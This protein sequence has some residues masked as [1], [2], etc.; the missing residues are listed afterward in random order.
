MTTTSF[1]NKFDW[2]RAI[3]D[4]NSGL[5]STQHHIALALS[6]HL[7]IQGSGFTT[8]AKL[9]LETRMSE[10]SVCDALTALADMHWIE[11][12][13]GK[14]G[15]TTNY[16]STKKFGWEPTPNDELLT[17]PHRKPRRPADPDGERKARQY[18]AD[19]YSITNVER[20]L[21]NDATSI[22]RRLVGVI[23]R[24][25]NSAA[26]DDA[27]LAKLRTVLAETSLETANDPAAVLLTRYK[28]ALRLYPHLR[29]V[30]PAPD[31]TNDIVSN[32]IAKI[33]Q[34]LSMHT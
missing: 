30:A 17:R 18:I 27:S 19:I 15:R 9:A 20:E 28:K 4:P 16:K 5:T 1:T 24:Q 7:N 31:I 12:T 26:G 25:M 33:G 34:A 2:V 8:H 21:A 6:Q 13:P 22:T 3:S 32:A 11:R 23:R 10:R 29:P 14:V